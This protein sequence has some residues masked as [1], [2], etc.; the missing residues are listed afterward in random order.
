M[1]LNRLRSTLHNK[2]TMCGLAI[3]EEQNMLEIITNWI[4]ITIVS[5]GNSAFRRWLNTTYPN[6]L[7]MYETRPDS[8]KFHILGTLREQ[9]PCL[10]ESLIS[11]NSG[12]KE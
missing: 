8:K 1:V 3:I 12:N 2:V 9:L 5:F 10:L 4:Q 11:R 6:Q 7:I